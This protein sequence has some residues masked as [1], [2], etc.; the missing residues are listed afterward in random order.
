MENPGPVVNEINFSLSDI[1]GNTDI[2]MLSVNVDLFAVN[3]N[4]DSNLEYFSPNGDGRQDGVDFVNMSTDGQLGNWEIRMDDILGQRV[5]TFSGE[6]NLPGSI[7][8]DG[9]NE[10][11]EFVTDGEYTYYLYVR[12]TDGIE[13][14]TSPQIITAV[15]ELNDSVV[16]TNPKDNSFTTKGVIEV[17]GQG[18]VDTVIRICDNVIGLSGE[19]DFE[20]EAEINSFNSFSHVIPLYRLPNQANTEHFLTARAYDKYGNITEQSN[21]VK[22]TVTNN[23]PFKSIEILPAFTGV[24]NEADYQ[25]IIDKLNSGEE[26]TQ[27]DIDSLRSVIFRTTVNQGTERVKFSF[28]EHT[29]LENLPD[30]LQFSNIGWIDNSNNTHLYQEFEDGITPYNQCNNNECSWD[31]YYQFFIVKHFIILI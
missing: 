14:T 1:A 5:K 6:V 11:G 24:N 3:L 21:S 12:T 29:N 7:D 8:W 22:I 25:L 19:C 15:T 18:P 17:Q 10:Y 13:F 28:A 23:S 2:Q 26:I 31:F 4:I 20:C 30:E 16:I 27:T 9:R